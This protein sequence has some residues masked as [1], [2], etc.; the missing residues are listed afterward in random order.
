MSLKHTFC[1][2]IL[3]FMVLPSELRAQQS[4]SIEDIRAFHAV[5]DR[6]GTSGQMTYNQIDHIKEAGYEVVINLAPAHL[7]RN[8][9]EGYMVTERSMAYVHIPVSWQEPAMRDLDL[10]FEVMKANADRKVYVHCFANMRASAFVY[11]Y[12]TLVEQVP[13]DAAKE[14]M[15]VIWDP[16]EQAQ[17]AA[18]ISKAQ[19]TYATN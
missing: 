12:R 16:T 5:S 4:S 7:E 3:A 17:W 9:L 15:H 14:D 2:L 1:Y 19:Q 13:D 10:F 8:G 6:L 18:L 11:L